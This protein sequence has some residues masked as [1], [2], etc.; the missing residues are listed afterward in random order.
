MEK[1]GSN[2]SGNDGYDSDYLSFFTIHA[3]ILGSM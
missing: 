3:Y 1:K 2:R